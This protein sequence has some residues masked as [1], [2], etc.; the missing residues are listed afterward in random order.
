MASDGGL[1][2]IIARKKSAE[3]KRKKRGRESFLAEEKGSGVVSRAE[4]R[5]QPL[6]PLSSFFL[7]AGSF[8]VHRDA[9]L[10]S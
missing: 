3:E 10:S 9:L 7:C 1:G 4:A 6:L 2:G 5:F 8:F